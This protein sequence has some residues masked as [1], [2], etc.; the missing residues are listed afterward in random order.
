MQGV[1]YRVEL[2]VPSPKVEYGAQERGDGARVEPDAHDR[3]A[4]STTTDPL[5]AGEY[6]RERPAGRARVIGPA[7][8]REALST[9]FV[10]SRPDGEVGSYGEIVIEQAVTG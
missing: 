6:A 7:V 8:I 4:L 2:I 5:E 3:A 1:S 9:T 10:C